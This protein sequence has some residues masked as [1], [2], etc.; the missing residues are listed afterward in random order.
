MLKP[1]ICMA[2]NYSIFGFYYIPHFMNIIFYFQSGL[3]Q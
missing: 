1:M 3:L 2:V